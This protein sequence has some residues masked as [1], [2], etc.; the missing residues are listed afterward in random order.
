MVCD[1]GSS[2]VRLFAQLINEQLDNNSDA[3]SS[4]LKL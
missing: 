4:K 3:S 1:E 2:L